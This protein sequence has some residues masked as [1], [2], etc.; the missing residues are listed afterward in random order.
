MKFFRTITFFSMSP[1]AMQVVAVVGADTH[2]SDPLANLCLTN[3]GMENVVKKIQGFSRHLLMLGGGGYEIK[4]TTQA[5]C[6]MWAAAN[7]IDSLP[8]FMLGMGGTFLGG[9]D[10]AGADIIDMAYHVTGDKKASI[11]KELDRVAAWH[12]NHTIPAMKKALGADNATQEK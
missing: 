4:S 7:R 12:E 11:L 2:R 8:D 5:W 10:I 9:E 3:N 6:R 1:L